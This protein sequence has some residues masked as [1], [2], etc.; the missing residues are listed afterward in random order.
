MFFF[1]FF[2]GTTDATVNNFLSMSLI[3]MGGFT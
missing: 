1:N 3:G 2:A